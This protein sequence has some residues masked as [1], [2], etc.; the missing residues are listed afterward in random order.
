MKNFLKQH[1]GL[2]IHIVL[3]GMGMV[4][5]LP[6]LF[7]TGLQVTPYHD[8][9]FHIS[10]IIGLGNVWTSPVSFLNFHHNGSMVNLCYPWLTMYP[11]YLLYRLTGG[12]IL[13]YKLS[14]LLLAVLTLFLAYDIMKKIS[15]SCL[16]AFVFSVLYTYSS[17]RFATIFRRSAFGETI[18]ITVWLVVFYGLYHVFYGDEKKWGFL[19]AGMALLAYTH[20]LSLLIA[21]LITGLIFVISIWFTDR[22]GKRILAL[23][24]A[25]VLAGILALGSLLPM[26]QL[27]HT[28]TLQLPGGSGQWLEES[29]YSPGELI[30]KALRNETSTYG[31]GLFVFIAMVCLIVF[32][33]VCSLKKTGD[34]SDRGMNFFA[35]FG[36]LITL[37]VTDLLPWRWIG[38]HTILRQLQF[39]WRFNT[40]STL[41]LLAAF[42][43]YLPKMIRDRKI[44]LWIP[45]AV[46]IAAAGLHARAFLSISREDSS[47]LMEDYAA[48]GD[49]TS[50][51]YAPLRAKLYRNETGAAAIE[52]FL[53][54][55]GELLDPDAAEVSFSPDGTVCT[56]RIDIPQSEDPA[57]AVDIPVFRYSTQRC[58]VNGEPAETLMS[59]RGSTIVS[60][61]SGEVSEVSFSYRY[62]ALAN[63][64]HAV[65]GAAAVL[66]AVYLVLRSRKEKRAEAYSE[67]R[68]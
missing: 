66:F 2:L 13:S 6:V 46:C 30:L 7:M 63:A 21:S 62:T 22:K 43:F 39:A 10:R 52:G 15:G 54:P 67:G 60:L 59:E 26:F 47:R 49:A 29:V 53:L 41:F 5:Y 64:A 4:Y 50:V 14:Y 19:A 25:A 28:D 31:D 16:S 61:P 8:G 23:I 37:A 35:L 24:Q 48:S 9:L 18:A 68:S 32:F 34:A 11:S 40:C 20:N 36:F 42:A 45:L 55:D 27:F 1:S 51:D 58:S 56:M 57:V 12:A 33:A 65:S 3:L 17:Y 38:N 44:A